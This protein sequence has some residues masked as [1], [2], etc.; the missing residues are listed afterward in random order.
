MRGLLDIGCVSVQ[1]GDHEGVGDMKIIALRVGAPTLPLVIKANAVLLAHG[2]DAV[3][4]ER[5]LFPKLAGGRDFGENGRCYLLIHGY[6]IA[7]WPGRSSGKKRPGLTG[8]LENQ[9]F[10][11]LGRK[12]V[13]FLRSVAALTQIAFH[14]HASPEFGSRVFHYFFLQ[15]GFPTC[16]LFMLAMTFS[17]SLGVSAQVLPY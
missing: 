17:H 1:L 7:A 13:Y 16:A 6:M 4:E 5:G 11:L 2:A 15:F 14:V 12:L 9:I 8:L 10:E 3:K